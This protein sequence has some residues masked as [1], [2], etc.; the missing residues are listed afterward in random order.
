M[1]KIV[2]GNPNRVGV[3]T[4]VVP[5]HL[6]WLVLDPPY[7][8]SYITIS[9]YQIWII[10]FPEPNLSPVTITSIVLPLLPQVS[11]LNIN[12]S[13]L[14]C[15]FGLYLIPIHVANSYLRSVDLSQLLNCA[16]TCAIISLLL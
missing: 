16:S 9:S 10:P 6:D 3:I 14:T 8:I 5:L 4:C 15:T 7:P 11:V 12:T 1:A 13:S 2:L